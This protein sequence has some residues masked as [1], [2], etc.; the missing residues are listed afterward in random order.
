MPAVPAVPDACK[1]Q[2]NSFTDDDGVETKFDSYGRVE[3]TDVTLDGVDVTD[4]VERVSSASF[5]LALYGLAVGDHVLEF[6]ATDAAGNAVTDEEVSSRCSR[7]AP[8]R[9]T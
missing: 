5:D 1:A 6:T 3:L 9:L 2:K 4:E 8:T 7:A